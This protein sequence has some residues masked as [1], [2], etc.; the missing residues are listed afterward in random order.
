MN[1]VNYLWTL[2]NGW[3]DT[4]I[5]PEPVCTEQVDDNLVYPYLND[6]LEFQDESGKIVEVHMND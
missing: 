2:N 6:T 1:E 5:Y 3:V 4:V